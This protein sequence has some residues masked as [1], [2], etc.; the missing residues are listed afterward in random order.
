M[1]PWEHT[2]VKFLSKYFFFHS[3]KCIWKCRLGNGV[4]FSTGRRVE[5][6]ATFPKGQWVNICHIQAPLTSSWLSRFSFLSPND[7]AKRAQFPVTPSLAT[8]TIETC[9]RRSLNYMVSH[10]RWSFVTGRKIYGLLETIPG[11]W[12][13]VCVCPFTTLNIFHRT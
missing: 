9:T 3:W 13:N 4:H 8:N 6:T 12:R 10:D 7:F 1:D 2:Q 11:K 5:I